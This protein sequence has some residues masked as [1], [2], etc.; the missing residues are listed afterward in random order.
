MTNKQITI[1]YKNICENY[2]KDVGCCNTF[3]GSCCKEECF[4]YRLLQLLQAKE[5]EC[6]E[7]KKDIKDIANLLDLDTGEEYSFGNIE[8]E[9]KEL[10][11]ENDKNKQILAEIEKI[12]KSEIDS[13][14]FMVVQCMLNGSVDNKNKILGQILQ[15]ISEC[16]VKNNEKN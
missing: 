2:S 7:L 11:T 9:I 16:E 13:K 10:K 6:E 4:T 1:D 5:Q 8:M 15:K 14:E 12:A 3:D